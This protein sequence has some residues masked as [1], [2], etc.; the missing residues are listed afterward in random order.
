[1][2]RVLLIVITLLITARATATVTIRAVQCTPLEQGGPYT[3]NRFC[4]AVDVNYTCSE[5]E[6]VRNFALELAVD[7]G[8]Y[9]SGI[10]DFNRGLSYGSQKGYGIFQG[11]FRDVI[12]PAGPNWI[13]P[14]YNP[15]IPAVD[16]DAVGTGIGT[17]RIIVELG[18]LFDGDSN[19]PAGSGTLFRIFVDPNGRYPSDCNMTLAVNSTR[20]G[21]VL[22]DGSIVTP[23]LEVRGPVSPDKISFADRFPCAPPFD[24]QYNEWVKVWRPDCWC[25]KYGITPWPYQCKG[26]ADNKTEGFAEYRVFT[27]DYNIFKSSWA[28][29][30]TSL[31]N[32]PNPKAT[33]CA[34]FDHRTEGFSKYR[35]FTSDY[36]KLITSW[37]LPETRMGSQCP[38]YP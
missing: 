8:F 34:D 32:N 16:K 36:K 13:D 24:A 12:N 3:D 9:I 11:K 15:I 29:A 18:T 38:I 7:N 14:C 37:S 4:N 25:G 23:I 21:V 20:R 30:A 22:E 31:R 26:D 27:S 28:L 1:M 10:R 5:N 19:R 33:I 6:K 17:N 2:R 35:V